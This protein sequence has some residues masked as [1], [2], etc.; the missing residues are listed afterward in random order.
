MVGFSALTCFTFTKR[1]SLSAIGPCTSSRTTAARSAENVRRKS[2][3]PLTR[4]FRPE[5][6]R[7]GDESGKTR[8]GPEKRASTQAAVA[9]ERTTTAAQTKNGW[10]LKSSGS[11]VRA[12][13]KICREE[14]LN[15]DRSVGI[16]EFR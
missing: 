11:L 4:G 14:I 7:G 10:S 1:L 12:P 15:P 6:K 13:A 5:A 8:S 9:V 16:A 2:H 3:T